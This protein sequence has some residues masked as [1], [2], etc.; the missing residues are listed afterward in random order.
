MPFPPPPPAAF[1]MTGKPRSVA[2]FSTSASDSI[3]CAEPGTTGTPAAIM[4]RRASTLSPIASI[5]SADG[6][7]RQE[8]IAGVDRLRAGRLRGLQDLLDDEVALRRGRRADRVR[9]VRLPDVQRRPVGIR[10]D[11]DGLDAKLAAGA[12]HA[13]G[14]LPAVRDQHAAEEA[15][16]GAGSLRA[17]CCHAS[18]AGSCRACSSAS[19]ARR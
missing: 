2:S 6:A 10:V 19:R 7:L 12:N 16:G 9:V 17:G 14:D 5:A 3:G 4:R 13:D 15:G 11:G 1:S 18:W 8:A